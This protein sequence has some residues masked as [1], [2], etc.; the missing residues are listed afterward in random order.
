MNFVESDE[1]AAPGR[2][3]RAG[4]GRFFIAGV[5][6]RRPRQMRALW[7]SAVDGEVAL[8]VYNACVR[9]VR[10]DYWARVRG[11]PATAH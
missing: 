10:A 4:R 3:I 11:R 7:L 1:S 9:M 6:R 2:C 8:E 5:H